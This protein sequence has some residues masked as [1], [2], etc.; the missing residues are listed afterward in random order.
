MKRLVQAF[1]PPWGVAA[2]V[3]V[4]SLL[5][6]APAIGKSPPNKG[7]K[8]MEKAVKVCPLVGTEALANAEIEA[9]CHEVKGVRTKTGNLYGAR[10]GERGNEHHFLSVV[11]SRYIGPTAARSQKLFR[12][13]LIGN[14]RPANVGSI[15]SVIAEPYSGGGLEPIPPATSRLS[16]ELLFIAHGYDCI[17]LLNNDDPNV[18]QEEVEYELI[19]IGNAIAG[20]L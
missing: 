3:L 13:S 11:I 1:R 6:A 15:A 16:G 20:K 8:P 12:N 14:G 4:L 2:L 17:V 18:D 10:W 19:V 5:A 7:K 9:P